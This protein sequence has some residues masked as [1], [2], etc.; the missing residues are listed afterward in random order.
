M[1]GSLT[2]IATCLGIMGAL[3]LGFPAKEIV[4][5]Y[6]MFEQSC[7]EKSMDIFVFRVIYQFQIS[8]S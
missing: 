2:Q 8:I 4:G 5:W 7:I 6:E 3:F 1:F